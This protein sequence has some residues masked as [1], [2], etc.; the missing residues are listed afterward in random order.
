MLWLPDNLVHTRHG[1]KKAG[2]NDAK[3][4]H[5]LGITMMGGISVLS[6]HTMTVFVHKYGNIDSKEFVNLPKSQVFPHC[7]VMNT[8]VRL[9]ISGTHL[10]HWLHLILTWLFLILG[11]HSYTYKYMFFAL[12]NIY[13]F[14]CLRVSGSL[15]HYTFYIYFCL[16]L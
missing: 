8:T 4:S 7:M 2:Q 16:N 13:C 14:W 3:N 9:R 1:C 15:L 12:C 10:L 5:F 6:L 11:I